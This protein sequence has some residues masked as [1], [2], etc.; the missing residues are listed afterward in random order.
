MA[1]I[2]NLAP[3]GNA[4]T[5]QVHTLTGSMK[6]RTPPNRAH[7]ARRPEGG[8]SSLPLMNM[9]PDIEPGLGFLVSH[10]LKTSAQIPPCRS[11]HAARHQG[12]GS[13]KKFQSCPIR[14]AARI[15]LCTP[16]TAIPDPATPMPRQSSFTK[17]SGNDD[18]V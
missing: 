14:A 10:E 11:F 18:Y 5:G 17:P 4:T 8:A 3:N 13:N 1:I 6:A 12:R 16:P 15:R 9:T 7:L 2:G